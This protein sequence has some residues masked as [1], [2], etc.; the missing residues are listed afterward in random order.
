MATRFVTVRRG[1]RYAIVRVLPSG[2]AAGYDPVADRE[3]HQVHFQIHRGSAHA[4]AVDAAFA[5]SRK[6][7]SLDAVLAA[8]ERAGRAVEVE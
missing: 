5:D 7:N 4:T 1:G 8:A 3:Q 2:D 6:Y